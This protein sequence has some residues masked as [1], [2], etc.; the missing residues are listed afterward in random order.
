MST[1][2]R[3]VWAIAT[4]LNIHGMFCFK[5]FALMDEMRNG[6]ELMTGNFKDEEV[7]TFKLSN[8]ET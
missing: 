1:K 6:H 4:S 5:V 3:D 7:Q 8:S 2:L